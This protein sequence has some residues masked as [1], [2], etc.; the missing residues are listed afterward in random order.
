M[1]VRKNWRPSRAR[2]WTMCTTCASRC[3]N[4]G[5]TRRRPA[6]RCKRPW[7]RASWPPL[8][9]H[10]PPPCLARP[11]PWM[12][13]RWTLHP[14]APA[15]ASARSG[16]PHPTSAHLSRCGCAVRNSLSKPRAWCTNARR[17]SK[18]PGSRPLKPTSAL[19]TPGWTRRACWPPWACPICKPWTSRAWPVWPG[20]NA[21][22]H[23]TRATS[24]FGARP[25][26]AS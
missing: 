9:A 6:P 14:T 2:P 26:S 20:L 8:L 11:R 16:G 4:A 19:A 5:P 23:V 18:P 15:H 22:W 25:M 24:A 17:A 1:N 10:P 13:G 12:A 7:R 21:T 3:K